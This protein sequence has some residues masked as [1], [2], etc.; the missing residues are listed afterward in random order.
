VQSTLQG[1]R[2]LSAVVRIGGLVR[3]IGGE[4]E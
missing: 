3:V 4:D 2:K 1:L